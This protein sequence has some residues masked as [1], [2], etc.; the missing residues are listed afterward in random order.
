MSHEAHEFVDKWIQQ[1]DYI[2]TSMRSIRKVQTDCTLLH[3]CIHHPNV[4]SSRHEGIVFDKIIKQNGLYGYMVYLEKLKWLSR[5][6]T[7]VDVENRTN[8]PFQLFLFESEDRTKK[9][10]RVQFVRE[11]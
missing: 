7:N 2:N 8:H 6:T 3:Q 5:I 4:L 1:L 11:S 9:K 10:I